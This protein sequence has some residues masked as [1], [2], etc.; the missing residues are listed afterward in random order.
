[1]RII[2]KDAV[3]ASSAIGGGIETYPLYDYVMQ[4]VFLKMTGSQEQKMKCVAW[5][6]ATIDYD[7]RRVLLN[8]DD[9]LGECSS[10]V[11][12]N[13]IYKRLVM[14]IKNFDSAFDPTKA[15][16]T[17]M[18]LKK[19]TRYI[20]DV[21][22]KSNLSVWA[23]SSFIWFKNNHKTHLKHEHLVRQDTVLFEDSF[24]KKYELLFKHRNRIAHNTHSYQQNLPT[25]K[26]LG[27]E[28]YVFE[29]YFLYFSILVLIDEIFMELYEKYLDAVEDNKI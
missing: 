22:N 28:D 20:G 12:K 21:F 19:T 6:M 10:F 3:S 23:Q 18:I 5:E 29:N 7:Y 16:N 4:S 26:T 27:R 15:V 11:D 9:K 1:L 8:N 14:Q 24:Q 2:L 17:K 13:K 25:L